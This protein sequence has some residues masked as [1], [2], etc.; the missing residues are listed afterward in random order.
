MSSSTNTAF[1][2]KQDLNPHR[3]RSLWM[4]GWPVLINLG[5]HT[6]F[7][8]VDLF[9]VHS[10]G[11][12]AV[13]AVALVGNIVFC[14]YGL[15]QIIY[16]GTLATLSRRIGAKQFEGENSA[17]TISVEAFHL[18]L[19]LGVLIAGTGALLSVWIIALFGVDELLST[20]SVAYLQPMMWSFLPLFP[21]MAIAAV[22]TATGDTRTPMYI[23]VLINFLNVA[24]DPFLIFGWAGL[25]ALGV[26]GAG[27][28]TLICESIGLL[29]FI[30][31]FI[32]NRFPFRQLSLFSFRGTAS[33]RG[34]LRIGL[35]SAA[36]AITR[37]LS[38]L[39]LLKVI[40]S[41]G[42][43]GVAA[44]GI[45]IRALSIMWLFHGALSTAVSTLTGQSLGREDFD[46]IKTLEKNAIIVALSLSLL[47]GFL[48]FINA[49]Q[50]IGI[51]EQDNAQVITLGALFLQ[52]LVIASFTA[53]PAVVWASVLMGAGETRSPMFIAIYANWLVKL[54]L[55]WFLALPMGL[56]IEGIWYAMFISIVYENLAIYL[57][58][59]KGKW[60]SIK[61]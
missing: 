32:S 18:G 17:A 58:Y 40:A 10:L 7:A 61:V 47:F 28:A 59:R 52:L 19:L 49:E 35:P 8:V 20:F 31:A 11:T 6:L 38:T 14:M 2:D 56:A 33:W 34:M 26:M 53:A 51:F 54:P 9:W 21:V 39:F 60:K 37:P 22:F 15:S 12:E 1:T 57:A 30:Y 44:F 16:V 27:L 43:E 4:L 24:L 50:I 13:A 41:F 3:Y 36:A 5:S 23:A 48:Y 45:T 46:G 29:L 55:A 42:A 25:P